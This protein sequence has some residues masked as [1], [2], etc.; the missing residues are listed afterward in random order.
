MPQPTVQDVHVDAALTTVSTAYIQSADKFVAARVFPV[1]PVEHK[2][3]KYHRFDKDDFLRDE[4][5]ERAPSSESA[6]SGFRVAQDDYSARTYAFHKDVDD[7]VRAN[8]DPAADVDEA[9]TRF[10]TQ[11]M[12]MKRETVWR[13]T[14]FVTGAWTNQTTPAT[15]W[16]LAA[17]TPITDI[18]TQID[19]IE[20][21]TGFRPNVIVAGAQVS[22]ALKNHPDIIDRYKFVQPGIITTQLLASLFEVDE[23]VEMR[24]VTNT[25]VEGAATQL[26]GYVGGKH[27]L[28]AYRAV[29]PGI[30]EPTAGY[31]FAWTGL[32]GSDAFGNRVSR[33]RIPTKRS[34]RVEGE[35]SFATKKVAD[36]LAHFFLGAVA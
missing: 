28:L 2:S 17:S 20:A 10:V 30:M 19:A 9:A 27:L 31:I 13:D 7:E 16:Q 18:N 8:A 5:E 36:D 21:R 4:A 25:A 14:Y 3:D 22:R 34:D 32:L 35:M 23:F 6:G 11:K 1:V 29:N 26:P 33:F 15:L 24:A 12:L